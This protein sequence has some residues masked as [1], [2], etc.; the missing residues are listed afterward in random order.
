MGGEL[1]RSAR[2]RPATY[3]VRLTVDGQTETQPF[4]VR[5]EPHLL[6]DVTDQDLREEF[7]LAIKVR[8]KA[9]QANDAVL[10]VRGIKA[11]IEE[12]KTQAGRQVGG[13]RQGARRLRRGAQR[14]RRARST[15]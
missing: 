7:D 2:A 1:A 12:R 8:D 6:K 3:Q 15:R 9:S 14:D 5:R 11:Q 10:L 13:G 4:A